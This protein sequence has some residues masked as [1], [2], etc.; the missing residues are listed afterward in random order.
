MP[1][2]YIQTYEQHTLEQ[3]KVLV[4]DI[5][6]TV[7]EAAEVKPFN[8]Q[9]QFY[10]LPRENRA[11]CG[12]LMSEVDENTLPLEERPW[13]IVQFQ[14]FEGRS[15]NQK[16]QIAK[17]V[18]EDIAKNFNVDPARIQIIISE[19]NRIHN[20]IGGLLAVDR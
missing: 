12:K 1:Q 20:S 14:L 11:L 7:C 10:E 8:V 6:K 3:K 13:L 15:L 18:T 17:G 19:M 2:I 9:I 5:T 4:R 16:R